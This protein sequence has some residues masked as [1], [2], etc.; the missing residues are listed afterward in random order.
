MS[1]ICKTAEN[2]PQ[3]IQKLSKE[4]V[5]EMTPFRRPLH[6]KFAHS[7][8]NSAVYAALE[9]DAKA[10]IAFTHTSDTPIIVSKCR[11]RLPIL[12]IA[13]QANVYRKLSL[14]YG[15]Y[16]IKS[17][18]LRKNSG[19]DSPGRDS[20]HSHYNMESVLAQAERDILAQWEAQKTAAGEL[21]LTSTAG[22][23]I[24]H[25]DIVVFCAGLHNDFHGLSQT[26][27]LSGFGQSIKQ[28]E[29]TRKWD[30]VILS[31]NSKH[32]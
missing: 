32:E 18:A 10:I 22:D 20:I 15:V 23:C 9:A 6:S 21:R 5:N 29:I 25:D 24:S 27:K 17:S 7:I 12:A 31:A 4:L 8:A 14:Y 13:E 28:E 2:S 19:V 26:V 30:R 3:Y 1:S 16:P 11:S